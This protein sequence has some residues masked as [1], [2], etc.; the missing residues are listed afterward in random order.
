MFDLLV[1]YLCVLGCWIETQW[2]SIVVS[3]NAPTHA[4][5]SISAQTPC[6]KEDIDDDMIE[7]IRS[8]HIQHIGL[9]IDDDFVSDM[10]D[11]HTIEAVIA[12]CRHLHVEHITYYDTKGKIKE[13]YK[14]YKDE[15]V[16]FQSYTTYG[17]PVVAS[18]YQQHGEMFKDCQSA[19]E[20]GDVYSKLYNEHFKLPEP[21]ILIVV[22]P[23]FS[24]HGFSPIHLR[25]TE[26]RHVSSWEA[27]EAKSLRSMLYQYCQIVHRKGK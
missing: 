4:N 13:N 27:L 22:S 10:M 19:A 17:S 11:H 5:A 16:H 21:D 3:F 12:W 8:K 2:S 6:K 26:L 14:N 25:Y 23:L 1:Y 9:Y 18:I 20:L 24:V 15:H 7:F